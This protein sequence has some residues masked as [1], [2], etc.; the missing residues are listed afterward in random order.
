MEYNF[1]SVEY[2]KRKRIINSGYAEFS[3]FGIA[4]ASLNKIL[5]NSGVSKGF[6]YHYF[7]DK[8]SFYQYLIEHGITLV[9]EKLN[10]KSLL[11]EQDFISRLQKASMYK[12][13]L[14]ITFPKLMDFFTKF[15]SDS[16]PEVYEEV[17][18][19]LGGDFAYRLRTENIDFSLFRDDISIENAM[20]IISRYMAQIVSEVTSM[21]PKISYKEISEYYIKELEVIR[22]AIYKKGEQ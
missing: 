18:L 21:I 6:F 3:E 1:D 14:L 2:E 17:S 15:Y 5:S 9:V 11:D 22:D 12:T 19:R 16:S 10:D 20:K 13:E 4:R 7:K 8:D